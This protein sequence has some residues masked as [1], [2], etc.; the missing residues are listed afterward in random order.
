MISKARIRQ[1]RE[2]H[3]KSGRDACG[4]F[5]VEGPKMVA[6]LLRSPGWEIDEILATDRYQLPSSSGGLT[7]T[8]VSDAELERISALVKPNKVVAVARMREQNVKAVVPTSGRH[9]LLDQLQ[10]PGN[11]GTI[12]RIADWFGMDSI[13]CSTD[14]ADAYNPKVIQATMGSI[15][16]V[17]FHFT[18][19][20]DLLIGNQER[21]RLP[22]YATMLDGE[23]LYSTVLAKDAF[24]IMG[25]EGRGIQ[26]LLLPFVTGSVSIP[27][28]SK[29]GGIQPESLNV[30]VATG[31]ICAEW[32]R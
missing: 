28:R 19:L 13:F 7:V 8:Q 24:V 17:D 4:L 22:V 6:E 27:S 15:F 5:M 2:L 23:D 10:D 20:A 9:L 21:S 18:S 25:N 11:L 31:I 26:P 3:H 32:T 1:L 16:R 12:F 14:T 30:A 29:N